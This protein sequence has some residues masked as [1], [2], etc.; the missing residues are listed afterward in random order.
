MSGT[1]TLTI[2]DKRYLF[3]KVSWDIDDEP[4]GLRYGTNPHQ[5]AAM[6]IP[7]DRK[8]AVMAAVTWKKWGKDGPS[9]TNI[10]DGYRALRIVDYFDKTAVAV[11]KHLNP[12]GVGISYKD[13]NVDAFKKAWDGDPRAA[14]GSTI[15]FN[16]HID[17]ETAK[18]IVQRYV[19]CT[20]A[21]SYSS[22]ALDILQQ[23]AN[24]R[25]AEVQEV[26]K[27]RAE[28]FPYEIKI[29]GNCLILEQTFTT[30]IKSLSDLE[31]CRCATDRRPEKQELLNMLYSWWVCSEKRSNGVVIWRD[32]KTLAVGTGQQDRI[33]AI[34]IALDRANRV[35]HNLEGS[36]LASDGFMLRDNIKPLAQAGVTSIIQPGG[37]RYDENVI[38]Q[39]EKHNVSML[40]TGERVFRHF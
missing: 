5:T 1:I 38:E 2:G 3:C 34:E 19:E 14:Y 32:D 15:A 28:L 27:L 24:L 29:L 9:A 35:G 17:K 16:S 21:P 25:V 20:Y 40:F 12:T 23:K 26:D 4:R 37:S 39:C 11:M 22:S 10:E 7:E 36:A 30:K 33:G 31:N 8:K 18:E 13:E 6:Y